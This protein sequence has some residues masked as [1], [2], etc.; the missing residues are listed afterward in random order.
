MYH[1]VCPFLTEIFNIYTQDKTYHKLTSDL[2]PHANYLHEIKELSSKKLSM[3][4]T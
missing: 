1:F 2:I 3:I 4:I